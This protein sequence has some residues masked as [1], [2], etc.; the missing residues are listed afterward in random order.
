MASKSDAP[1][2]PRYRV[3]AASWN[4]GV[5]TWF[6]GAIVPPLPGLVTP[7]EIDRALAAGVLAPA[8]DDEIAAWDKAQAAEH[9]APAPADD[10]P[11]GKPKPAA[12][13]PPAEGVPAEVP[14]A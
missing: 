6:Q 9:A 12:E 2:G 13:P 1:T 3:L 11:A 4:T 8:T 7:A 10:K 14:P 5:Y